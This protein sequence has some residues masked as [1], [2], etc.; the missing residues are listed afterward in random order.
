[1]DVKCTG[2]NLFWNVSIGAD[3]SNYKCP[4]CREKQIRKNKEKAAKEKKL[5]ELRKG[6]VS[7]V[8]IRNRSK[9]QSQR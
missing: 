1:M 3:V 7:N 2:C 4:K 5:K 9:F 6:R 8:L